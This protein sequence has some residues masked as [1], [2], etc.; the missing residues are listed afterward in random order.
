[1]D[2][3]KV[4][5]PVG[6]TT[7]YVSGID[8]RSCMERTAT[9]AQNEDLDHSCRPDDHGCLQ[10]VGRGPDPGQRPAAPA[11]TRSRHGLRIA[12]ADRLDRLAPGSRT[13]G[14]RLDGRSAYWL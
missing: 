3:P 7:R 1:M 2:Y 12:G 10:P 5:F 4:P 6:W 13:P 11:T 9:K 8:S 14:S